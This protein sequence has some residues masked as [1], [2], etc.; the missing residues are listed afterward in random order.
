MN[1][2]TNIQNKTVAGDFLT[3][4]VTVTFSRSLLYGIRLMQLEHAEHRLRLLKHWGRGFKSHS[5]HGCL[6]AFILGLYFCI[7]RSCDGLIPRA[8]S[9]TDCVYD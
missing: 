6:C 5:R 8:R 1:A 2:V 7:G 4:R 3:A 9:P